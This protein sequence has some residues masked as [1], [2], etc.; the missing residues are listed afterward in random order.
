[1]PSELEA[2]HKK[3]KCLAILTAWY[4]TDQKYPQKSQKAFAFV[5][6]HLFSL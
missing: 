3:M 2:S 4:T 5:F 1:V 6:N